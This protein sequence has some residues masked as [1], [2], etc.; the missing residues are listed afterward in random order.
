MDTQQ[1]LHALLEL[2]EHAIGLL[3]ALGA[4]ASGAGVA[5]EAAGEAGGGGGG[6]GG[7]GDGGGTPGMRL[8]DFALRALLLPAAVWAEASTPTIEQQVCLCHLQSLLL[9]LED[10]GLGRK[11]EEDVH[12]KYR[13][14]LPPGMAEA[15]AAPALRPSELLPALHDLMRDQ[16]GSPTWPEAASLKTYLQYA[17]E[18]DLEEQDWYAAGFPE[19]LELRHTVATFLLLK[20]RGA[21]A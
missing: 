21:Q 12:P 14:A 3:G 7:G 4:A 10:G 17:S 9:A 2:L 1:R 13:E 15:L 11:P 8:R 19:E 6:G 5:G 18:A 20:Q 16:L